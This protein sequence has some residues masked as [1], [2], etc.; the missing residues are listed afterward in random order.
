MVLVC[1]GTEAVFHGCLQEALR[2]PR[3][4]A[5]RGNSDKTK[6]WSHWVKHIVDLLETR[7]PS[8][9]RAPAL[10][11]LAGL[12]SHHHLYWSI[13]SQVPVED[14]LDSPGTVLC[15]LEKLNSLGPHR[16][17]AVTSSELKDHSSCAEHP[18][19]SEGVRQVPGNLLSGC[20]LPRRLHYSFR[21]LCR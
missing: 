14:I 20:L 8:E 10:A 9:P 16:P 11:V 18:R 15:H 4:T 1:D 2:A 12:E 5:Y 19:L 17:K 3:F 7:D 13:F 6:S 21:F